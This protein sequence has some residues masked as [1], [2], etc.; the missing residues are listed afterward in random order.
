[1]SA[2][3]LALTGIGAYADISAA[4][5]QNRIS[6]MAAESAEEQAALMRAETEADISRYSAQAKSFKATQKLAYLKSGVELSGSPLDVLDETARVSQENI[7]AMRAS[8]AAKALGLQGKARELRMAGRAAITGAYSK[9]AQSFLTVAALT[10]A[11][12]RRTPDTA[13]PSAQSG[14]NI[15]TNMG[16]WQEIDRTEGR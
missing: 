16:T 10:G 7:N 1:M 4:Q 14:Q 13:A 8:G 9:T 11:F 12:R 2:A 6:R 3:T 5:T 15:G